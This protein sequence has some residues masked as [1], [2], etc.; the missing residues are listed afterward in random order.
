MAIAISY[1][2]SEFAAIDNQPSQ[3][4]TDMASKLGDIVPKRSESISESPPRIL[5][6]DAGYQLTFS[7]GNDKSDQQ[8]L[9]SL[10]HV[11]KGVANRGGKIV[12]SFPNSTYAQVSI[13]ASY[14]CTLLISLCGSSSV[15]L[16]AMSTTSIGS[17]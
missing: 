1:I 4:V 9:K 2:Y 17:L 3:S 13:I 8:K 12:I 6:L 15:F 16:S 7:G 11:L 10:K 14:T 5:H